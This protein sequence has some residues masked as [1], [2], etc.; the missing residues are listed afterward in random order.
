MMA[1]E[2]FNFGDV[3]PRLK[4]GESISGIAPLVRTP[5]SWVYRLQTANLPCILRISTP[6]AER[7]DERTSAEG[8]AVRIAALKRAQALEGFEQLIDYSTE[9]EA[10]LTHAAPGD[11]LPQLT[12]PEV[13]AIRLEHLT[14]VAR[15]VGRGVLAEVVIDAHP[16]NLIFHPQPGITI[17]DYGL[18][19][20]AYEPS[21]QKEYTEILE[22]I[23]GGIVSPTSPADY[24]AAWSRVFDDGLTV[25]HQTFGV[26]PSMFSPELLFCQEYLRGASTK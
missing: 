26:E 9:H 5:D 10:V 17:I 13:R 23:G 25:L 15:A 12:V 16:S 14:A 2:H 20:G 18:A 8:L 24:R 6:T 11:P 22:Q 3:V 1:G 21:A 7:D 19:E 4:V